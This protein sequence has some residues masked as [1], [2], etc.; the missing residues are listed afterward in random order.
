MSLGVA[1]MNPPDG[2]MPE[3]SSS[4]LATALSELG[5]RTLI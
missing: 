5:T 3:I 4:L 2:A 1:D